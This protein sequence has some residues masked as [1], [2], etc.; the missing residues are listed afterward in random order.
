MMTSSPTREQQL[1]HAQT[2][3]LALLDGSTPAVEAAPA[4]TSNDCPKCSA[5]DFKVGMWCANCGYFPK[6][7]YEG[8]APEDA[9]FESDELD[10]WSMVPMWFWGLL[11]VD[12]MM[13]V[14]A[15]WFS[16]TIGEHWA[17][18]IVSASLLIFCSMLA[19]V[20]HTRA[21]FRTLSS[22]HSLGTFDIIMKPTTIWRET[23][24]GLP[25][26]SFLVSSMVWGITGV[27]LSVFVI[28]GL[29]YMSLH[30]FVARDEPVELPS[31]CEVAG[32]VIKG[33]NAM[34][35]EESVG[36]MQSMLGTLSDAASESE[37]GSGTQDLEGAIGNFA[38]TSD[39][40]V[41]AAGG[42]NE[43]AADSSTTE[44]T[45][46]DE[47]GAETGT[48]TEMASDTS[49]EPAS[50]SSEEAPESSSDSESVQPDMNV[51]DST[52][53]SNEPESGD[54]PPTSEV[55]T[56]QLPPGAVVTCAIV[57]YTV[58][59]AGEP[60]SL[61]L[62]APMAGDWHYVARLPIGDVPPEIVQELTLQFASHRSPRPLV[63]CPF[64][65]QWLT[66]DFYCE[67]H[68]PHSAGGLR[69]AEPTFVRL[70]ERH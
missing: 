46:T 55:S 44:S 12:V 70:I 21:Y 34:Q 14:G 45:E 63:A 29:D 42:S 59:T 43:P 26:S 39:V 33:A 50:E 30:Q 54:A 31:A 9:Q 24:R 37:G 6:A 11:T 23:F 28:G 52:Q 53:H 2:R 48:V 67:I 4:S 8:G 19:M 41:E 61:L 57:G 18:T 68:F 40:N 66:P 15:V 16:L 62:A 58:N 56:A 27:V 1:S 60:R 20:A 13:I 10:V 65:G 22:I 51:T 7:G 25:E 17:R 69:F 47:A 3:L 32:A 49:A 5:P 38:G 35:S 36:G 64:G